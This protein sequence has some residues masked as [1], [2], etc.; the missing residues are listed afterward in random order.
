MFIQMRSN[1]IVKR[2][3][4]KHFGSNLKKN[5]EAKREY[6][7]YS[8]GVQFDHIRY[9]VYGYSIAVLFGLFV[10]VCENIY[11]RS[12]RYRDSKVS[13]ER[14]QVERIIIDEE[15]LVEILDT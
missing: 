7:V 9:I 13:C 14:L 6:K 10:C 8:E 11:Y 2:E 3:M 15:L 4:L 5:Y 12:K 1:G